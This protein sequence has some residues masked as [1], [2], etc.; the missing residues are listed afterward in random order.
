MEPKLKKDI[1]IRKETF[2][3]IIRIPK[4]LERVDLP[5]FY[6]I[7]R[8]GLQI[9][10]LCNGNHSIEEIINIISKQY[11][12]KEIKNDTIDF[13]N[14]LITIGIISGDSDGHY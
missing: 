2:G 6:Q 3:A 14:Q 1:K 11:P 4:S 5:Q 12:D 7:N 9:L 8:L 10:M 13:L